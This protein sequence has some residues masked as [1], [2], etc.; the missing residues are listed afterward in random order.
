MKPSKCAPQT[1]LVVGPKNSGKT[2]YL[3][4]I[5]DRGRARDLRI[6]GI[7]SRGQWRYQKK[8]EYIIQ[9][10]ITGARRTLAS[11]HEPA[12]P[13]VK[14]GAYYLLCSTLEWTIDILVKSIDCEVILLDEFGPLELHGRGYYPAL[15]Y[16]L[17]HYTGYLFVS[18]RPEVADH[19]KKLIL[20]G[21]APTHNGSVV[22]KISG[23]IHQLD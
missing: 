3:E 22:S 13:S 2:T 20:T 12:S 7:V 10:I 17:E 4:T 15:M 14:V 21:M 11:L 6:G 18:V 9:D 23:S 16:L 5:I 8:Q 1:V 19:L